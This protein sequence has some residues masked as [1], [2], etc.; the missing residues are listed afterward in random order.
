MSRKTTKPKET[1]MKDVNK[2]ILVGRLGA[3]P[4]QRHT[5]SGFPVAH[6]AVATSRRIYKEG[7]PTSTSNDSESNESSHPAPNVAS[8]AGPSLSPHLLEETQWHQI[9]AWGK[10]GQACA[11]YLKKGHSVYVEG[12]IRSR[13]WEAKDGTQKTSFE[14]HTDNIS[15]LG[16]PKGEGA[17]DAQRS[18]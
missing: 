12:M 14:I 3:D 7:S 8:T 16:W 6:F 13:N 4:I 18:P 5:K 10:Q 17:S 2:V 1:N 15:F 11:Q 9:V